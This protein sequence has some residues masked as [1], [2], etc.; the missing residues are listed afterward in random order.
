[1][2]LTVTDV[3]VD[4]ILVLH[5]LSPACRTSLN[6]SRSKLFSIH[7]RRLCS[8]HRAQ[9]PLSFPSP[10]R[11]WRWLAHCHPPCPGV[12]QPR[13]VLPIV[14]PT[15][16]ALLALV[17]RRSPSPGTARLTPASPSL[18]CLM[19]PPTPD[20]AVGRRASAPSRSFVSKFNLNVL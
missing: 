17:P 20:T 11:P 1:M 5:P 6:L 10:V 19:P 18:S 2:Y 8:P 15:H 13:G 14:G 4:F 9:P 12:T 3:C 16:A 7:C